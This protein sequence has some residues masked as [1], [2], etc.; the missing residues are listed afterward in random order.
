M[1][2][3]SVIAITNSDG[4]VLET[5]KY[6]PYGEPKN[7]ADVESWTGSRF[8]Y[9]G[10]TV[11]DEDVRLNH[12][13]ARVYDPYYGRFLQT[14]PIG[15]D[16]DINLYAYVGGDPINGTDPT[17][18]CGISGAKD[19][20][21]L[22]VGHGCVTY[23]YPN[24]A[25]GAVNSKAHQIFTATNLSKNNQGKDV[26]FN[27]REIA[28][29]PHHSRQIYDFVKSGLNN[30]RASSALINAF[31]RAKANPGKVIEGVSTTTSLPID[32]PQGA[33]LGRTTID[34]LGALMYDAKSKNYIY[35]AVG[36]VR[37]QKFSTDQDGVLNKDKAAINLFNST[38]CGD[39]KCQDYKQIPSSQMKTR[40]RFR[41]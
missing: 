39:G 16:D 25:T 30:G 8:R 15:S 22:I 4:G 3:Y 34:W 35:D 19:L 41:F 26:I 2:S 11:L 7:A 18:L 24:P 40:F 37:A 6:G 27:V 13:K 14:D 31:K 10:Q 23:E 9:T 1:D 32:G 33:G 36:T 17:G 38:F 29:A 28:R 20:K 21:L 12:Y 5:Y